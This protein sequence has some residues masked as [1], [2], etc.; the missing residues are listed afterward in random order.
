MLLQTA[1][2]GPGISQDADAILG[3]FPRTK[4]DLDKYDAK[5]RFHGLKSLNLHSGTTDPSKA[6][7]TMAYSAYR[8]ARVPAPRTALAELTLTVPGKYDKEYFGL[9][10]VVEQ[11][12][13][14]FLKAHFKS[15][16]GLLL[17]PDIYNPS[18]KMPPRIDAGRLPARMRRGSAS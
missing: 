4:A 15:A 2:P 6:R 17:N 5:A 9:Y 12:D 11:V 8:A 3:E 13:K 1:P 18:R 10:T 7:E 14:A 16:K